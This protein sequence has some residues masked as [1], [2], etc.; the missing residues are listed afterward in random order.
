M[1]P[2]NFRLIPSLQFT[3]HINGSRR[4]YAV[5]DPQSGRFIKLG[6]AEYLVA[7]GLQNGVA[8]PQIV[9]VLERHGFENARDRVTATVTW[10]AKQGLL[11]S[12]SSESSETSDGEV[13]GPDAAKAPRPSKPLTPASASFDPFF[14]RVPLLSGPLAERLAKPFVWLVSPW[15]GLALGALLLFAMAGLVT[16]SDRF[17]SLNEKLFVEDGR[18]WWLVAWF[19]LKCCHEMGHAVAAV[20]T[21]SR[22]RSAGLHFIFLAPVPYVDVTD[23][24]RVTNGRQRVLVSAAGMLAE[25]S[26]AS[27]AMLVALTSTNVPLQY[28]CAALATLG[29]ITTLAFNGNPLMKFDGYYILSD[30][31]SRPNLWTEAQTAASSTIK[32][33]INPFAD[34]LGLARSASGLD[35]HSAQLGL[36]AFGLTT[37]FYRVLMLAT[38]AWWLLTVWHG[39]GMLVMAWAIWGWFVRPYWLKRSSRRAAMAAGLLPPGAEVSPTRH[40]AQVAY[41]VGLIATATFIAWLPSPFG[42][43]A[44]GV[45]GYG[46]PTTVRAAAEGVLREVLVTDRQM[47]QPGQLIARLE[48]PELLVE[49]EDARI[50]YQTSQEQCNALRAR[51]EL[52]LLQAEQAKLESLD[53]HVQQL[54]DRAANLEVRTACAGML[55]M[56]LADK[57]EGRFVKQGT[58]LCMI[59]SPQTFEVVASASQRDASLFSNHLN[60]PVSIAATGSRGGLGSLVSV[61]TRGSEIC[62]QQALAARYGGPLS[63]EFS[64]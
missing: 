4:W 21:G 49:L 51:G 43:R 9:E 18:L 12:E 58:P 24:W 37:M 36:A 55:L 31:L 19:V 57:T 47:V 48:N 32:R 50:K 20:S 46:D 56:S 14:I 60:E 22:I 11:L 6:S 3:P 41:T 61:D 26:V 10:L 28:M 29:T 7:S 45:V 23:L 62:D 38:M 63:V 52:A 27:V 39:V 64:S 33:F 34:R 40:R 42:V 16:R 59:V 54:A 8:L 1:N 25:M 15:C 53:A 44:P 5:E 13:P 2:K 17:W 35:S 30:Y